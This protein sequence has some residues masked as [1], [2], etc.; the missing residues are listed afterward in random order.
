MAREWQ[1]QEARNELSEVV[2]EAIKHGPQVISRHGKET[3]VVLSFEDYRKLLLSQ[4]KLSDFFRNSPLAAVELD[5]QRD[6]SATRD[7]V[8]L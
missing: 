5:L 4:Q 7:D 8:P 3:A 1:I 2:D 6:T